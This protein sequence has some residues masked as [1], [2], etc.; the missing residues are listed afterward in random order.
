MVSMSMVVGALSRVDA[1][2][3]EREIL[4]A[5]A[6]KAAVIDTA[7]EVQE[8]WK[9]IAPVSDRAAHPLQSGGSYIEHPGDYRNSI[10]IHYKDG[11]D[12]FGAQ[13]YTKSPIAHWLEY[14]SIHNPEHG[15]AARVVEEFNGSDYRVRA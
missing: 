9:E 10:R 1:R 15:Y 13:V 11:A 2:I 14:G 4:E 12:V 3:L 8:R 7:K 6:V 5:V